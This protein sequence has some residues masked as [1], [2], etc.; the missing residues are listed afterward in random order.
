MN[1]IRL[2]YQYLARRRLAYVKVFEN[3]AVNGTPSNTVL[4]DLAEFCRANETTYNADPRIHAALEGRRE[5]WLRIQK[6]LKLSDV[7]LWEVLDGR[8]LPEE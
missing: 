5:V 7:E 6:H 4:R 1:P 3:Y 2:A 8:R